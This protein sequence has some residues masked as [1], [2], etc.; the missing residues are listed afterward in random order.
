MIWFFVAL[1][2]IC[3][4]K[5]KL[6]TGKDEI[7]FKDYMSYEKTTSIKGISILLVFLSHASVGY[8]NLSS[9]ADM[10]YLEIQKL[11]GQM[12]VTMFFFYSG[13]GIMESVKKKGTE[14][15]KQFPKNRVLTTF[16]HFDIAVLIFIA[17]FYFL[18]GYVNQKRALLS[19]VAWGSIG[20]SNWF[21]FDILCA[22]MLTFVAFMLSRKSKYIAAIF[23][24]ILTIGFV[25]LMMKYQ[26]TRFYNTILCYP[27]GMWFSLFKNPFEKIV[28]KNRF[29]Y[30]AC[31]IVTGG[32]YAFG[33]M[34][35]KNIYVYMI[36]ALV[37]CMFVV[38]GTMFFAFT[39]KILYWCGKQLFPIYIFMKLPMGILDHYKFSQTHK[40]L[41]I[42]ISGVATIILAIIF[43]KFFD[44][45]DKKIFKKPEKKVAGAVNGI[46]N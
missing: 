31:L 44:W 14:Y 45:I 23:T 26:E 5:F 30:F 2:V 34:H 8:I 36:T 35:R 15:I 7:F 17:T 1:V 13:Y 46:Q 24:T 12:I 27:F 19:L 22:Y 16:C 39:N 42:I 28:G 10:L 33:T 41:F 11:M 21:I 3:L 9:Q 37:F 29:T 40:Y 25:A 32:L 43:Q 18:N 20:N 38:I 6:S 4:Y